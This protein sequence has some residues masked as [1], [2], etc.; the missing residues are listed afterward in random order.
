M[1]AVKDVCWLCV[2][3]PMNVF[4]CGVRGSKS[5]LCWVVLFERFKQRVSYRYFVGTAH[6]MLFLEVFNNE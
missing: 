6:A 1:P 2:F 5:T 3:E 4:L